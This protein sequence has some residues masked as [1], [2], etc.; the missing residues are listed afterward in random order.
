MLGIFNVGIHP[1]PAETTR[2]WTFEHNKTW[3]VIPLELSFPAFQWGKRKNC[4]L[5]GRWFSP[6]TTNTITT[7]Q[8]I[9]CSFLKLCVLWELRSTEIPALKL[10]VSK[11]NG[12]LV[13]IGWLSVSVKVLDPV[14]FQLIIVLHCYTDT[15]YQSSRRTKLNSFAKYYQQKRQRLLCSGKNSWIHADSRI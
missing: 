11:V 2:V 8:H 9:S 4:W 7:G 13:V 3:G 14:L 10:I 6:I 5:G 15:P 12:E 1:S